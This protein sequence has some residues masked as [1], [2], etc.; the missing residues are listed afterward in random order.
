MLC[1]YVI[2]VTEAEE[3]QLRGISVYPGHDLQVLVHHTVK[4]EIF[5]VKTTL[6]SSAH[7]QAV[8]SI[9]L[10]GLL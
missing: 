3:K 5:Q 4:S 1:K 8:S 2:R 7:K 6:T 9:R 10:K